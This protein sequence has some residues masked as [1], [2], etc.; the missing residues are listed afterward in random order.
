MFDSIHLPQL[1][2]RFYAQAGAATADPT[3]PKAPGGGF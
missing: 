2:Q 1:A 3:A